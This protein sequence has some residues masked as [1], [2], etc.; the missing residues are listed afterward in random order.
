MYFYEAAAVNLCSVPVGFAG[1]QTVHP[2]KAIIEDGVTP[3]E[4]RFCVQMAYASL[5]IDTGKAN[6]LVNALLAKFED[7]IESPPTGKRYQECFDEAIVKFVDGLA[8]GTPF[9]TDRLDNLETLRLMESVYRAAG[10]NV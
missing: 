5:G 6:E 3:L 10:V 4:A 2:A 1:V 9:E 7:Q 8:N